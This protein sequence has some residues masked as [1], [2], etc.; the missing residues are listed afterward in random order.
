MTLTQ[1]PR[2]ASPPLQTPTRK[3]W[4]ERFRSTWPDFVILAATLLVLVWGLA[5]NGYGNEY[6]ARG[7]WVDDVFVESFC[8]A[9]P[10]RVVGSPPTSRRS[11]CGSAPS[12]HVFGFSS[13]SILLPSAVCGVA[14]V[15]LVMAAVRRAWG[16]WAGRAAGVT[17]ALTPS[18]VAV[19]R[20]NNPDIVLVLFM[21]AAAYATQ[22]SKRPPT[23]WIIITGFCCG[24]AFLAKLSSWG[25]SCLASSLRTSSLVP[26]AGG[27]DSE[28]PLWREERSCS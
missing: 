18:F 22:H 1:A 9:L 4:V 14:S 6:Y 11:P 3:P 26:V 2:A 24:L 19:A 5:K 8:T 20:V 17:L 13:W 16:R 23:T 12:S 7:R 25:S 10:T 21:V 27:V 15:A 28:T